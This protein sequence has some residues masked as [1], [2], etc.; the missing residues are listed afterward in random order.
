MH[1]SCGKTNIWVSRIV[2]VASTQRRCYAAI[3]S[4]HRLKLNARDRGGG[5]N[6]SHSGVFEHK[7]D[8]AVKEL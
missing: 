2:S 4:C 8:N 6:P 5:R 3:L 7:P 1:C